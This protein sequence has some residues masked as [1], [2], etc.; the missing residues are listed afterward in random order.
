MSHADQDP[1]AVC[2]DCDRSSR[3]EFLR[4]TVGTVAA[5]AGATSLLPGMTHGAE[6]G[7]ATPKVESE[8]LVGQLYKSLKEGQRKGICFP[9][10]HPL[11]S[12]VDNNWFIV[13]DKRV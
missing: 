13:K 4:T 2:P 11:R 10:D 7:P 8:T 12:D 3:R 5:V 9:F 6:A 1:N